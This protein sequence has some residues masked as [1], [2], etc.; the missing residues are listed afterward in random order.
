MTVVRMAA[1]ESR[2]RRMVRNHLRELGYT[3]GPGG[4]LVPPSLDK[5]G[6]RSLHLLQRAERLRK[7]EAFLAAKQQDLIKCFANGEEIDLRRFKVRL[8]LVERNTWQADL[9]RF[10]TLLW[11]I[12]VSQG[13]GRR[14]RYLVWDDSNDRLV[15]LFALTDPVFNLRARDER[16]GWSSDDRKE[17]LIYL[18]DG[19]VVGAVPPYNRLLGGKLIACLMRSKEVVRDFRAKYGERDGLI[20]GRAK[21][22]HLVA[23]TTTS[24][25]GRSSVYNRLRLS[26]VE[27]LS[28]VGFTSG[29]G[30]FHFPDALFGEMRA[31]LRERKDIYEKNHRFGDGPNWKMRAIRRSLEL[32]NL[33][34][35]L[36]RHGLAREVFLGLVADNAIAVLQGKNVKPTYKSLQS[37]NDLG[38]AAAERWLRRRAERDRSYLSIRRE[39]VLRQ[40]L[41]RPQIS[42]SAEGAQRSVLRN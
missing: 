39:D 1:R 31:Y 40:V 13:F 6:Y 4:L 35:A 19:Y 23:V 3:K 42:D 16:I 9:F 8:E 17:R 21:D 34:P 24:A 37:V 30:H 36:I 11:S 5:A 10:A 12:P 20:S 25:L 38:E 33:N 29:Y 27:Y 32:L 15:G 2:L 14:L 41:M 26:G 7:E 28:S 22:A 18:M